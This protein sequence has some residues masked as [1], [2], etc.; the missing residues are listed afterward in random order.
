MEKKSIKE[1]NAYDYSCSKA[2]KMLTKK[3]KIC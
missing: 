2:L 1:S 3:Q